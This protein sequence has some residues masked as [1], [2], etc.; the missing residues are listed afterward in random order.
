[1][2]VPGHLRVRDRHEVD[3]RTGAL[4][5]HESGD[6]NRRVAEIPL[7]GHVAI[8]L[9]SDPEAAAAISVEQGREHAR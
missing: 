1:V 2:L 9:R 5:G 7:L 6:E 4:L 8:T 3:H